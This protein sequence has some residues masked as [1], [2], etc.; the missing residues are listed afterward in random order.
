MKARWSGLSTGKKV[1]VIAGVYFLGLVAFGLIFGSDGKNDTFKPQ[2]E[3]RLEPG[4][5]SRSSE[6]TCRSTR[7]CSIW[8]SR[9]R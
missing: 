5:T 2:D 8:R 3:F 7:R 1:L 9:R 4:S 6:S